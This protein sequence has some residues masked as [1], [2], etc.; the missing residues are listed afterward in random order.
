[1]SNI[2]VIEEKNGVLVLDEHGYITTISPE[3]HAA[4]VKSRD[5]RI[6]LLEKALAKS[7]HDIA[8]EFGLTEDPLYAKLLQRVLENT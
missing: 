4:V 3:V 8:E 7:F 6:A 1:M 2:E 5:E